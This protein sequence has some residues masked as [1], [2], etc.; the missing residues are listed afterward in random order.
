MTH[1]D[2][3]SVKSAAKGKW[4]DIITS[5]CGLLDILDGRHHPCPKCGGE[6]RFNAYRDFED[7]GGV[8][9]NNCFDKGG[10]GF[11]TIMWHNGVSFPDALAAVAECLGLLPGDSNPQP[12]MQL[13]A[14]AKGMPV[15]SIK[16]YGGK[17]AKR[18]KLSVV[19]FP[20]CNSDGDKHSYFDLSPTA[21]GWFKRGK[22]NAGIFLPGRKPEP[23]ETWLLVEGPK[24]ACALH[25]LG[26][27]AL[28]M[29]T[30]YLAPQYAHLL[31]GC[32]IV[33]VP[34]CDTA[35]ND[36]AL[37]TGRNIR[38][39]AKSVRIARLPAPML[40]KGGEDVRDILKR[41][42]GES[43][44]RKAIEEAVPWT[45]TEFLASGASTPE[46]VI[47][48]DEEKIVDQAIQVIAKR[49]DLF[50]R[51]G[52]LCHIIQ[53]AEPPRQVSRHGSS[54]RIARMPS[55]RIRELLASEIRWI[56]INETQ[57]GEQE[58][59][60]HPP[61]WAVV[62]VDQRGSWPD[63]RPLAGLV[64]SPVL[65]PDGSVLQAP[66]YDPATG[67][68]F[69]SNGDFPLIPETPT[70]DDVARSVQAL[71]DVV[72]DFPFASES[73]KSAWVAACL[74]PAARH[75]Y[76]GSTPLFAIDA[77][78]RA[79]GKSL[80][81]D[82]IAVIHT[83]LPMPRTS[84]TH[85]DDEMRKRL[86]SIIVAAEPLLLFD[87]VVGQLGC[88]S[89][90]AVLTGTTWSDRLLG[91]NETTGH[92]PIT[93]VFL[94]TGNNL[95]FGADTARRVLHIRLESPLENPETRSGFRHP[96]L[97]Q[98][99]RSN[100]GPL[101]AASATILRGYFAEGCPDQELEQWGSFDGWS[102]LVRNAV[103]WAGLADP[104]ETR[105]QL[106]AESDRSAGELRM[107]LDGW[108]E[109]D[110][111]GDG[112]SVSKALQFLDQPI[113]STGDDFPLLRSAVSE[114]TT[115]PKPNARSIGLKIR[116]FSNRV[117][118]GRRF[119][120]RKRHNAMVWTVERVEGGTKGTRGTNQH[121]RGRIQTLSQD[122]K[123]VFIGSTDSSS[124][125]GP[126]SPPLDD[127]HVDGV[128]VGAVDF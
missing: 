94:A 122:S 31:R 104:G 22:G 119:V 14:S 113:P 86:T 61:G 51:A 89:L 3:D 77:N 80:L 64:Q 21:K 52:M 59:V 79:S 47:S 1:F 84:A 48:P 70:R 105:T 68:F 128:R 69:H 18:G 88:A 60:V 36:G 67:L 49:R 42:G 102:D 103:V 127:A 46:I 101:V 57:Q 120:S 98:W 27:N 114:I 58:A 62:A 106:A 56:K 126:P 97:L 116:H 63:V 50:Q 96:K 17:E 111:A 32:D 41:P 43:L 11:A 121:L 100:R 109:A 85:D 5:T 99:L 90:D 83:G 7:T 29:P 81:A 23:G 54:L 75:A 53:D 34:D 117:C 9:C 108:E 39:F 6:D 55:T 110:P 35:A 124:P 91:T 24:D 65:R 16:V 73:H 28:G 123:G 37:K 19:R 93:T 38:A 87:N 15:D 2:K 12:I 107:L 66:G 115:G 10:D 82:A 26:Y 112:L 4:R 13:V 118:G 78:V 92:V 25:A 71:L 95:V 8:R 30:C 72:D 76:D 74:T 40:E 44:V 125:P 45:E 33:L 20:V